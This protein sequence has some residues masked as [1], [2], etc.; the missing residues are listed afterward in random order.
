MINAIIIEDEKSSM[1]Y[2]LSI[3]KRNH[4]DINV[5]GWASN[6][7]DA[8]MLIVTDKPD[9]VFLDI[10]LND[11]SGFDVLD[12]LK[13]QMTFEVIFT[14]GFLDYKEKAMDYFAFYYLNKPVQETEIKRVL[15]MY[16]L[17]HTAFNM[18]KYEAF[19]NQ[20]E[21]KNQV[22]TIFEKDEYIPVKLSN[23]IYCEAS[24]NY[25]L[26]H[27]V[28]DKSLVISKNLKR[29]E[30]M[31]E[32]QNFHRVHRSFLVNMNHVKN[33]TRNGLLTLS[34]G[35]EILISFRNRKKMIDLLRG[36]GIS[37]C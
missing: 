23:I 30:D 12:H 8:V 19:K 32:V 13:T 6:V 18:R 21:R 22:I 14:T 29:V 15:D 33:Y 2:L 3:L 9:I 10:E 26:V 28:N 35:V 27:T 16:L 31:I 7:D 25:T 11:G 37:E 17:K 20:I 1:E 5:L 24:G 36:Y 34:N 4:K